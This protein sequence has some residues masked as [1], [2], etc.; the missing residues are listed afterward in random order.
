MMIKESNDREFIILS[1]NQ[2]IYTLKRIYG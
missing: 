1:S 2:S